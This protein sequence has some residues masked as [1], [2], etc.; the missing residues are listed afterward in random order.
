MKTIKLFLIFTGFLFFNSCNQEE[1]QIQPVDDLTDQIGYWHNVAVASV[2]DNP[3]FTAALKAETLSSSAVR[4]MIM[5]ELSKKD[6][7]L[8][9]YETIRTELDWSDRILEEKEIL[10]QPTSAYLRKKES[11]SVNF[12]A[13]FKYLHQT[14]VIGEGLA[15]KFIQ[16]NKKVMLNEVSRQEIIKLCQQIENLPLSGRERSYVKVFNQVLRA[17][18]NYWGHAHAK[19]QSDR[20]VGII[21]AD[22]AGGLYGMLCGPV[23]SIIEAAMFSTLVAIQ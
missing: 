3:V 7:R 18:D 16:L 13:I 4:D 22:A 1:S 23:C 20:T 8:F 21:W 10:N 11:P 5:I 6:A 2:F 15:E 14:N 9:D 17:S 19:I 12:E